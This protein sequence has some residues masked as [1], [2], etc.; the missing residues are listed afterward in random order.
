ML[1]IYE[2][3]FYLDLLK[4]SR[5]AQFINIMKSMGNIITWNH[6]SINK[7]LNHTK[8]AI[9]SKKNLAAQVNK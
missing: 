4:Y 5:I 7:K 8:L 3:S 1:I 9:V 6:Y 2:G